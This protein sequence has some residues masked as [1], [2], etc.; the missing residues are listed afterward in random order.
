[1]SKILEIKL[2]SKT[3]NRKNILSDISL[4]VYKGD[5]IGLE[6]EN[7]SG[8]T[9]FFK[10]IAGIMKPKSGSGL[11]LNQPIFNSNYKKKLF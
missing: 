8:K 7:G 6:G 4:K 10:I 9:T 5:I 3:F 2:L 1:M 11:L